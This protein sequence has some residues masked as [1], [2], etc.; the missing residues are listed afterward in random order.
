M[1]IAYSSKSSYMLVVQVRMN[2]NISTPASKEV[3]IPNGKNCNDELEN[4][5]RRI[6][7]MIRITHQIMEI[8]GSN[9]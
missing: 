3:K 6:A 1:A 5:L 9:H 7:N 2:I 8:N 4:K